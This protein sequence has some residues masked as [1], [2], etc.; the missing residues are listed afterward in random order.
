MRVMVFIHILFLHMQI[1]AQPISLVVASLGGPNIDGDPEDLSWIPDASPSEVFHQNFKNISIYQRLHASED[2]YID[3]INGNECLTY[4]QYI[5]EHYDS[6]P[7]AVI[8]VHAD[9]PR[10]CPL[11]RDVLAKN[12]TDIIDAL[13]D[14]RREIPGYISLSKVFLN[15]T[16]NNL[17]RFNY[18]LVQHSNRVVRSRCSSL[19][20]PA[21]DGSTMPIDM[22]TLK[23]NGETC[24]EHIIDDYPEYISTYTSGSFIVAREN[25]E[26]YPLSFYQELRQRLYSGVK[27]IDRTCGELEYLWTTIWG[28]EPFQAKPDYDRWCGPL[29]YTD[30]AAIHGF[31]FY[32]SEDGTIERGKYPD[33]Y[34]GKID[35]DRN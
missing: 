7:S 9:A 8:F 31:V 19:H 25:I 2:N 21:S 14:T 34:H 33:G 16:K 13:W 22:P 32:K 15:Q 1:I 29:F 17:V 4:V 11:I 27:H 3:T 26:R 28:G 23:T 30:I 10:H 5:I 20:P 35:L 6:L 18:P 24:T 12:N